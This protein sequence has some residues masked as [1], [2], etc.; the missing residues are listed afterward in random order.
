M[1]LEAI[2][3]CLDNS[4]WSRNADFQ[5]NRFESQSDAASVICRNK[6][7]DNRENAAG[8]ITMAGERIEV[9]SALTADTTTIT[10]A[11]HGIHIS[12]VSDFIR[13][14]VTAQLSLKHRQ[15]MSQHQRIV[16]F[17]ASP[18]NATIAQLEKLGRTL[19]KNS[20]SLDIVSVGENETN[21]AKL[22]AL[23]NA[24]NNNDTSHLLIAET[25]F[26]VREQVLNSPILRDPALADNS[27][28]MD[29]GFGVDPEADPDLYVAIQM[30]LEE[31]KRKQ[32]EAEEAAAIEGFRDS[33]AAGT[34]SGSAAGT[35]AAAANTGANQDASN[36]KDSA[37]DGD[38][39]E[40]K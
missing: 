24:V 9:R 17:V 3:V 26:G 18:I 38:K 13:G 22:Q 8:V 36:E 19:R 31:E 25:G 40:K 32:R 21:A 33:M 20:I 15:N 11:L 7:R 34:S 30:S 29:D 1:V 37:T 23:H 5:I 14:I 28:S 12:G 16:V 6:L 35:D 2:V 4:D 10:D 39:G 27:A